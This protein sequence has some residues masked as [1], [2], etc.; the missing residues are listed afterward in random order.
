MF[1]EL[2]L[3]RCDELG[4]LRVGGG[5]RTDATQALACIRDLNRLELVTEMMRCALEAL[6]PAAPEWLLAA[7]VVSVAW[8]RRYGQRADS[9]R[10]HKGEPERASFA[11]QVSAD[12]C[13]LLDLVDDPVAPD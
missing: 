13:R 1:P 11:A 4:L 5:L 9:Y 2:V 12:G 10:L 8:V 7:G 3:R 6:E